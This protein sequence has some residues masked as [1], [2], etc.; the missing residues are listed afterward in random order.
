MRDKEKISGCS[1]EGV[2]TRS[3]KRDRMKRKE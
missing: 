1:E 3:K 2:I